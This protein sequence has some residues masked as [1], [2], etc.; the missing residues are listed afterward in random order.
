MTYAGLGYRPV[1][2]VLDTTG[3]NTGNYT[4]TFD[5]AVINA[6]VPYFEVY[7]MY[8]TSPV[9]SGQN[10]TVQL[11][12]N[13]G[14][15]DYNLIAQANAWDPA[16]PMIMTPGDTVFF[17]FNVPISFTP[18]PIVTCWFRYDIAFT[19]GVSLT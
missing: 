6:N 11:S 5:P 4:C 9:L 12:L 8:I 18:P 19:G 15:W 13:N 14:Q 2:G 7:H 1:A 17:Y 16:Q 3:M 10:T